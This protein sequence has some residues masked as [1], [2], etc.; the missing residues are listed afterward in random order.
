M[1]GRV[2]VSNAIKA[3]FW[4]TVVMTIMM[5]GLPPLMGLPPMDIMAALGSVFPFGT[6]PYVFGFLAHFGIG[7]SLAARGRSPIFTKRTESVRSD[8]LGSQILS[9]RVLDADERSLGRAVAPTE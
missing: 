8:D 7:I 1:F 9:D 3:G 4:G 6:S 5:Y 2:N